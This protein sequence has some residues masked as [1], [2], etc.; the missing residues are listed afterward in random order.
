MMGFMQVESAGWGGEGTFTAVLLETLRAVESIEFV[1][2]EDTPASR[3]EP[4]YAFISNEIY[5]TFKT[6]ARREIRRRFGLP[7]PT[8]AAVKRMS[9]GELA[10]RLGQAEAVGEPDYRD[11]GML[12]YLRTERIVAPYQTKGYK[13]VE[14]V[15]VYEAGTPRRV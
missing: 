5:V 15:R 2:V 9:L 4:G 12:Q 8:T 10:T 11:D 14:M 3:A 1:R 7:W 6:D 13:V